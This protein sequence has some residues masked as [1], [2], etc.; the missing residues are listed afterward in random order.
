MNGAINNLTQVIVS[1]DLDDFDFLDWITCKLPQL[2]LAM[3]V[4]AISEMAIDITNLLSIDYSK[5]LISTK[6]P[7]VRFW[8]S[9]CNCQFE[10]GSAPKESSIFECS[11]AVEALKQEVS[12]ILK[13]SLYD[14]KN[15]DTNSRILFNNTL[16]GLST[17]AQHIN[18]MQSPQRPYFTV[19]PIFTSNQHIL[20]KIEALPRETD[21]VIISQFSE[22]LDIASS[23]IGNTK[24][25]LLMEISYLLN[26]IVPLRGDGLSIYSGSSSLLPGV[27]F[28]EATSRDNALLAEMLIHEAM[29]TKL[30]LLQRW[31]SLFKNDNDINWK[32][33][34]LYSPWR[35]CYRPV[36]GVLHGAFV[37]TVISMFWAD[38]SQDNDDHAARRAATA[39][40]E[41]I[42]AINQLVANSPL[43]DWGLKLITAL[44]RINTAILTSYTRVEQMMSW[45]PER[46]LASMDTTI[47]EMVNVHLIRC[48]HSGV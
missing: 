16:E 48:R 21:P 24:P 40:S 23:I 22:S 33:T 10:F 3:A 9:V 44:K 15:R 25:N 6:S 2:T 26:N 42:I 36:Q 5:S 37:F 18:K 1:G 38:L 34:K 14:I 17:L 32:G 43:T 31:D 8:I 39:A 7:E 45:S 12:I 30:F 35:E 28:L 46:S 20:R 19:N 27:A 29:H 41:S 11:N 4:R 47:G 13:T